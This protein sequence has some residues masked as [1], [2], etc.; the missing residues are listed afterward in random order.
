MHGFEI[1]DWRIQRTYEPVAGVDEALSGC[2]P[3]SNLDV[4]MS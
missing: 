2:R 4:P 1:L 3:L